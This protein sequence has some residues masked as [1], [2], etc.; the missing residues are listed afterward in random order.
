MPARSQELRR[1][2][3]A[4]RTLT[5]NLL[6]LIGKLKKTPLVGKNMFN[7]T[8]DGGTINLDGG[9]EVVL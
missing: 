7:I 6:P 4:D 8:L 3:A 5:R 1:A 9:N 2:A